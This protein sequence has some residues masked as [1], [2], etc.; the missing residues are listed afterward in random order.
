MRDCKYIAVGDA[1]E[2]LFLCALKP[3]KFFEF[4]VKKFP[5]KSCFPWRDISR[6]NRPDE[7]WGFF[8]GKN[9]VGKSG[10]KG[11]ATGPVVPLAPRHL[12]LCGHNSRKMRNRAGILRVFDTMA[13]KKSP[14]KSWQQIICKTALSTTLLSGIIPQA[15][16]HV[17]RGYRYGCPCGEGRVSVSRR[18]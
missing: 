4:H 7:V 18:K 17:S 3:P 2:Y 1:G 10:I 16:H 5:G 15:R 13:L 6:I 14:E 12:P 8:N 9:P 11:F